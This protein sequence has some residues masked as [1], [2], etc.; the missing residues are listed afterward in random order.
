MK[1]R[2]RSAGPGSPPRHDHALVGAYAVD[3]VDVLDASTVRFE[4]HLVRCPDCQ[5]EVATLREAAGTLAAD[6]A[7]PPPARVRE[8][9][10]ARITRTR[11]L[12]PL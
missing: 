12:P 6:L 5:E 7:T 8:V 9:V 1:R 10:M 4:R 11:P 2:S 3:A